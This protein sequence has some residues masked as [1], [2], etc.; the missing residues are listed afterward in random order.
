LPI[1]LDI[2][3]GYLSPAYMISRTYDIIGY[4]NTNDK[5]SSMIS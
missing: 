5:L 1:S 2:N 4:Q 3:I